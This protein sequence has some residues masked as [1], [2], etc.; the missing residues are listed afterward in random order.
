MQGGG[1]R[2]RRGGV[3]GEGERHG[4]QGEGAGS[5]GGGRRQR[6]AEE[7]VL[8]VRPGGH[9]TRGERRRVQ[10]EAVCEE[11]DEGGETEAGEE[12][13][14][15]VS[16][17]VLFRREAPKQTTPREDLEINLASSQFPF[18]VFDV[19]LYRSENRM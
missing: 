1:G 13:H 12:T 5:A 19:K 2:V 14:P 8:E 9:V 6:S 11:V 7:V 18:D 17:P 4:L 10:E 3:G 16:R 15:E